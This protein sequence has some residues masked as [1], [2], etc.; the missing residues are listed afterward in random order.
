MGRR[1][2]RRH[3]WRLAAWRPGRRRRLGLRPTRRLRR[4]RQGVCDPEHSRQHR[5]RRW[6]GPPH[7]AVAGPVRSQRGAQLR[8]LP[9]ADRRGRLRRHAAGGD[10]QQRRCGAVDRDRRPQHQRRPPLAEP[11]GHA[12]GPSER[13]SH[14]DRHH[15]GQVHR[16][17]RGHAVDRRGGSRRVQDHRVAVRCG[18]RRRPRR[19]RCGGHPRLP[20]AAGGV[21]RVRPTLPAVVPGGPGR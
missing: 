1:E 14:D 11:P 4:Q 20:G 6:G 13:R 15:E 7:L 16:Q 10:Q 2:P 3:Q 21:G 19:R 12:R 9:E 17:R 5:R 18:N 8:L